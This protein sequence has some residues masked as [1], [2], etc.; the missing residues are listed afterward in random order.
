MTVRVIYKCCE[1][2]MHLIMKTGRTHLRT[3]DNNSSVEAKKKSDEIHR[4]M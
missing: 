1:V 2:Q 4:Y 3:Q